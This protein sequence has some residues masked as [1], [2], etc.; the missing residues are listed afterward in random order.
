ME[1]DWAEALSQNLHVKVEMEINYP[2]GSARPDSF[3][4]KYEIDGDVIEETFINQ[5]GG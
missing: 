5:A 3:T 2:S 1:S 4:V